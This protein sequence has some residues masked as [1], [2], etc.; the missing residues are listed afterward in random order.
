MLS[1]LVVDDKKLGEVLRRSGLAFLPKSI[2]QWWEEAQNST[3][4]KI[5]S[6]STLSKVRLPFDVAF[7]AHWQRYFGGEREYPPIYLLADSSPQMKRDW[8][9]IA[10][11]AHSLAFG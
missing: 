11:F 6:P 2:R 5:P 7:C 8:F 3:H 9:S 10:K 1:D 4:F